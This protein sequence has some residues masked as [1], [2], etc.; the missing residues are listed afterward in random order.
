LF[1]EWPLTLAFIFIVI[2]IGRSYLEPILSGVKTIKV[3]DAVR[4]MN[5]D[6]TIVIDVRL[7]NE[8]KQGHILDSIHIPVG[9][10]E[11]RIRELDNAKDKTILINCQTGM[12]S[13]QA[14]SILKKHGFNDLHSID[15]GMNGWINA[16]F[17]VNKSTKKK[18]EKQ[19]ND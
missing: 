7:E 4:L 16:N 6:N 13:K 11:S 17:P 3:Q 1:D 10:L 15:G 5:N 14:G 2:L 9:A 8:F 19:K 18:K 12:R